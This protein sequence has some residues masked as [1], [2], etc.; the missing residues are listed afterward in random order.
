MWVTGT[1]PEEHHRYRVFVQQRNQ[2]QWREEGW[3]ITFEV[4]KDLWA[5]SGV[6]L[7]RGRERGDYCMTRIDWSLPWSLDNVQIITR[8]EHARLQ[9]AAVALGWRSIAQK[10]RRSQLGLPAQPKTARKIK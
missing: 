1:D 2:A 8:Q 6:W 5:K 9:G 10:R 3:S 7:N 4:W